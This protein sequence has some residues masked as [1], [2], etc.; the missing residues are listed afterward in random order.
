[1]SSA[2][3]NN[4]NNMSAATTTTSANNNNNNNNNNNKK[5]VNVT[6]TSD[7]LCPWCWVGLKKLQQASKEASVAADV[8]VDIT[9]KPFLLRPNIPLN[10]TPKNGTPASRVGAGL[11]QAGESVGIHFTGLTD[12]TPNTTMFH[13]TMKYLQDAVVQLDSN[14]ITKFHEAVFEGYFTLGVYPDKEGLLKAA[15]AVVNNN[16]NNNK[17]NNQNDDGDVFGHVE[18]LFSPEQGELLHRLLAEV[19]E[20]ALEASRAGVS[21][22]PTFAFNGHTA[23]SGAQPVD[24]FVRHLVHF[25]KK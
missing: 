24:T 19:A 25:S 2:D 21:G 4:H 10:G 3:D 7:L 18:Y 12:R 11:R 8:D 20:E 23:F 9:W 1:V 15:A 17:N 6:I 5:R 14:T 22:V 13:A 16:N